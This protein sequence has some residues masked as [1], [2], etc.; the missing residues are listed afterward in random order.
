MRFLMQYPEIFAGAIACCSMDPIV[1]VHNQTFAA[2]GREKD[3]LIQLFRILKKHSKEM[4][5]LGMK[6]H[7]R[8]FLKN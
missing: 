2:L 6:V 4:Y 8:W 7:N 5:I 1:P 3:P